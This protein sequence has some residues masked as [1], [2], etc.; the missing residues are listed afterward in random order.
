MD[1][2]G[3]ISSR[4]AWIKTVSAL[5]QVRMCSRTARSWI[6]QQVR[7]NL[8]IIHTLQGLLLDES[9]TAQARVIAHNSETSNGRDEYRISSH[10]ESEVKLRRRYITTP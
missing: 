6:N 5:G 9:G 1:Y 3:E 7:E 10:R 4:R 8:A 2:I